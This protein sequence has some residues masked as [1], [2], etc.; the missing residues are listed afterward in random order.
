[1][2]DSEGLARRLQWLPTGTAVTALAVVDTVPRRSPVVDLVAD[3]PIFLQ[4]TVPSASFHAIHNIPSAFD[5]RRGISPS[6]LDAIELS[7]P[8]FVGH[9]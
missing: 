1:V 7:L 4:P 8:P 6:A 2:A 9:Q 5:T 3:N